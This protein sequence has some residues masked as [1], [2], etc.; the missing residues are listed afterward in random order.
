V[1]FSKHTITST[2]TSR[3]SS[4]PLQFDW[5][6]DPFTLPSTSLDNPQHRDHLV[7]ELR[8]KIYNIQA[9]IT[10]PIYFESMLTESTFTLNRT[11]IIIWLT[12]ALTST[13]Y[14]ILML[15]AMAFYLK[16]RHYSKTITKL[17]K[18]GPSSQYEPLQMQPLIPSQQQQNQALRS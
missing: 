4:P 11:A 6:W 3:I 5:A 1:K 15:W 10:D 7:N 13:L 17:F 9:N 16:H 18:L 2:F 8:N 12:L 14:L